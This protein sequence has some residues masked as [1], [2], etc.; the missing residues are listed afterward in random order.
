MEKSGKK[1][2]SL[3]LEEPHLAH[4]TRDDTVEAAALVAKALL[5]STK[6]P[7]VLSSLGNHVTTELQGRKP[8]NESMPG[9][10]PFV[11]LVQ[12]AS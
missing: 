10:W 1:S 9:L 7:E 2:S 11:S 8:G 5:T 12:I 4:E 3:S 6:G